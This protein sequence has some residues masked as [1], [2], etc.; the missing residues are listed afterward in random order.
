MLG[1]AGLPLRQAQEA[2]K[3]GRLEEA[4]RLLCQPEAQGLKGSWDLLQQVARAFVKRGQFHLE[5]RDAEAAWNDLL[6]AEQVGLT[7]REAAKLRQTLT[8]QGVEEVRAHLKAGEP[9]RACK[10]I[11]QL[12]DRQVRLPELQTLEEGA[13]GWNL[14]REQASR[15]EFA[16]A[17]HTLERVC[18]DLTGLRGP[19]EQFCTD[20]RNYHG[21]FQ[22]AIVELHEAL[23]GKKWRDVLQLSEQIL[24]MAPNHA[25]ARKARVRAWKAIEPATE[26]HAPA[27]VELPSQPV[28]RPQPRF[29]LWID[30]VG[31][32]LVCL[33]TRVNVGQATPDAFVDIPLFADVSRHHATLTREAEGY[34]LEAVRPLFV[35]SRAVDKRLLQSGDRIT[36]GSSCQLQIRQPVPV[37]ASARIDLVSG[38]RLP[39]ALEGVLL[40]ADTLVLGPGSQVH[41]SMPELKQPI[42]LYRHKDGLG[43][44]YQGQFQVDGERCTERGQLGTSSTV[45]SDEFTLAIEPVGERLGRL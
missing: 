21:R 8:R 3:T 38:H 37:S 26:A 10:F 34:V 14:A 9:A 44:R 31:G 18:R 28:L 45:T 39:L 22:S 12:R 43:I 40:M 30:S 17:G 1:F 24:A 29:L 7:D 2:L 25:E 4:Y 32:F 20:V 6:Q 33:G 35:N 41:V 5:Q 27:T 11:D 13:K 23:A 36:L 19:L 15:G 16:A 42:V